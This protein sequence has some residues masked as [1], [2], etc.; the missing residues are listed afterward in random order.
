MLL[1]LLLM[2]FY[3]IELLDIIILLKQYYTFFLMNISNLL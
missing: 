2:H 3:N 1:N